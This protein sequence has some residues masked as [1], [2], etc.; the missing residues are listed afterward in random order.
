[1]WNLKD[2]SIF[3]AAEGQLVPLPTPGPNVGPVIGAIIGIVLAVTLLV[4][5]A[6]ICYLRYEPKKPTDEDIKEE[7]DNN[8]ADNVRLVVLF[9]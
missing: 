9:T 3:C 8:D 6:L 5:A 7:T 1:M 4:G 2:W